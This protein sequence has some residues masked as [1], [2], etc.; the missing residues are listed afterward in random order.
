[1]FFLLLNKNINGKGFN[2]VDYNNKD[3]ND[4]KGISVLDNEG[5]T[6]KRKM[7]RMTATAWATTMTRV[8]QL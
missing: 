3:N 1:M 6:M 8:S 4:E 7:T 5:R 2:K